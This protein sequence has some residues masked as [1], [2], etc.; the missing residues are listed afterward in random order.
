[1]IKQAIILVGGKGTRLGDLTKAT[2]KPLLEVEDGIKFLDVVIENFS[3]YGFKDIILLAGF[4]GDQIENAYK[5]KNI[6]GANIRVIIEPEPQGTG[7]ALAFAREY[8]DDWFVVANGDSIFDFNLREFTKDATDN[9][10]ARLALR[11]VPDPARYGAVSLDGN[12]ITAFLE[13]DPS[14]QGPALINGGIYLLS[15]SVLD[16]IN[17]P[18]SIEADIFPK[19]VKMGKIEGQEF[20]GYFLDMGLPDSYAQ[21]QREI[22]LWRKKPCLFLDRDGVINIDKGY[23]Y[24]PEDLVFIDGIIDGIKAANE[25]GY[26]VIVATNQ[27][28]VAR[29]FYTIEDTNRFHDEIQNRLAKKGAHIDEFYSCPYHKDGNIAE[30]TIDNHPDRKPNP[31]MLLKAFAEWSIDKS[32]SFL[33]GD[34]KHDVIAA[35]RAGIKGILFTNQNLENLIIEN[36][37]AKS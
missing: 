24:K 36:L 29:G 2:P 22:P 14:L 15:R 5:N 23:T 6:H 30:F 35:E 33:I 27:A 19:L 28:G 7:G 10:I 1:M 8:L 21:S 26:Y 17:G 12:K 4:C 25:A 31:G 18:C 13:K 3:R 37:N 20:N 32:H 11:Q 9:F 34:K 16:L